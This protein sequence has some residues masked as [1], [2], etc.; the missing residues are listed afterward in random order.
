MKKLYYIYN[1]HI[2][3]TDDYS[4]EDIS[5]HGSSTYVLKP[6]GVNETF[7][8]WYEDE[9]SAIER[10]IKILNTQYTSTLQEIQE[11]QNE[12]LIYYKTLQNISNYKIKRYENKFKNKK[13]K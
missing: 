6:N 9:K 10:F 11:L 2:Y 12:V 1:N 7:I 8:T 3:Y 5:Y 4:I 13:K